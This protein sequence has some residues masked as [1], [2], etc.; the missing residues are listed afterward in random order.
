MAIRTHKPIRTFILQYNLTFD[1][2]L[3]SRLVDV[4][5]EMVDVDLPSRVVLSLPQTGTY[6]GDYILKSLPI[7]V[8]AVYNIIL[9]LIIYILST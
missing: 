3:K 1:T 5:F 8:F 7:H 4:V 9:S 2:L 6:V